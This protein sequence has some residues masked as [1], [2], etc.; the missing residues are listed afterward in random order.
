MVVQLYRGFMKVYR[1]QTTVL[2]G[3][4]ALMEYK[5]EGAR[6]WCIGDIAITLHFMYEAKS[7]SPS[8]TP[9]REI[10]SVYLANVYG[11]NRPLETHTNAKVGES[12]MY[13]LMFIDSRLE[14]LVTS[15]QD[16]NT[17]NAFLGSE[18]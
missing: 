4:T 12:C 2:E 5:V 9:V 17:L 6:G 14:V 11:G 3:S 8:S 16:Q 13:K 7:V 15:L 10:C 18:Y 1:N